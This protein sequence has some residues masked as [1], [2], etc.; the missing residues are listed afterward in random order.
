M[1][2]LLAFA[3][4]EAVL[5]ELTAVKKANKAALADWLLRTQK[6]SVNTDAVFDIQSKRLHEYKR[7]QL[8]LLYLIHQYYEIKQGTCC[9]AA[10]E[11]LWCQAAQ[12]I[13]SQRT[14]STPC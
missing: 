10:G 7:Q 9:R 5:D 14:S 13:P 1:E 11:H 4:D 8:N 12:P 6:V 3:D 2:K